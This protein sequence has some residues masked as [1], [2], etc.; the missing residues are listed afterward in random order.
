MPAE[1]PSACG[2]TSPLLKIGK[3]KVIKEAEHFPALKETRTMI[4]VILLK[5]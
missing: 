3:R 1:S 4:S 5:C 2:E